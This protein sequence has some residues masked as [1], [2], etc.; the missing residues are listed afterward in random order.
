MALVAA[1]T[2]SS[3]HALAQQGFQL[4]MSYYPADTVVGLNA[5]LPL[6]STQD[7]EHSARAG[8]VYTFAGSPALN[9]TYL[10][11]GTADDWY[12]TYIGAGVGLSFPAAPLHSPS[13]SGHAVAGVDVRIA[14]ALG[15]F[16][17]VTVAGNALGARLRL[18]AGLTY[19][20]GGNN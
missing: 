2:L 5:S 12:R 4:G 11:S 8:V 19:A 18:G 9:V 3:S 16:T 13:F 6:F 7:V 1:V 10:L 15:V 14:G 20:F 17:E